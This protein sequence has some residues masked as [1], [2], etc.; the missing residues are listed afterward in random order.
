MEN[1]ITHNKKII[2]PYILVISIFLIVNGHTI[3]SKSMFMDGIIYSS[4]AKNLF[5]G[6][7]S[8]WNLKFTDTL[9]SNFNEHPPLSMS[10][11]SFFYYLFGTDLVVD[12]FYSLSN[13]IFS[14]FI[15]VKIWKL[16]NPLS[17]I[18][19]IVVLFWILTP[20][21]F[22]ASTNNML[23]NSLTVFILTSF[24]FI[25]KYIYINKIQNILFAGFFLALGFLTKGFVVLFPISFLFIYFLFFKD[26]KLKKLVVG[27]LYLIISIII[28]LFILFYFNE[29]AYN[30][31]IKYFEIQVL[32]SI[33]NVE[34]VNTRF[35]IIKRLF[36]ELLVLFFLLLLFLVFTRKITKSVP[37]SHDSIKL[38][39]LFFLFALT[40]VL[41]ILITLKQS[42]YYILPSYPFFSI[43][44]VL[45]FKSKLEHFSEYIFN[46]KSIYIITIVFSLLGVFNVIRSYNSYG[47]DAIII[48]DIELISSVLNDGVTIGASVAKME[49]WTTHAYF[50]RISQIN[51]DCSSN[52][53]QNK[54]FVR[55]N[56]DVIDSSFLKDFRAVPIK[57]NGLVLYRKKK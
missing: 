5:L 2:F 57:A 7:C 48:K 14:A 4:I 56:D 52:A 35:F 13:Y 24:Y 18:A 38:F 30:S 46:R 21:V 11:Q 43:A 9:F 15:I 6:E 26:Y 16:I 23:E 12:K 1:L 45:L 28:P 41:P 51:I 34:T 19:W 10:L 37:I 25:L 20:V 55:F 36:S 47:K 29:S 27:T 40:G 31:I 33:Q 17:K 8:V 42:G 3:L 50:H 32:N 39:F 53:L 44:F 49:D 54:Y 22:W